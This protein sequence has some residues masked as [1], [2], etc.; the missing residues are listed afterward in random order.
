MDLTIGGITWRITMD[1]LMLI[2]AV[3][4]VLY[5]ILFELPHNS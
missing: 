4:L 5:Y 1:I 2:F 3:G